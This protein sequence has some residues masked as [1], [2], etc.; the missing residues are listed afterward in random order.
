MI[1]QGTMLKV[2]DNSGAL[3]ALCI[4]ILRK[5]PRCP[6]YLGDKIIVVIKTA[7]AGKRVKKSQIHKA[8]LV[9]STVNKR[10]VEGTY[11]R[12]AKPACV[13]LK[14]DGQPLANRVRGPVYRELRPLGHMR[15]VSLATIAL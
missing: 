8:I 15:L 5:S 3:T 12:F 13:L 2:I 11:I 10:R 9:W 4:K 14:K 7:H 6:G 1:H